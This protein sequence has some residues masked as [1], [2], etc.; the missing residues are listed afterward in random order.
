MI[1]HAPDGGWAMALVVSDED[2]R[3]L[4]STLTALLS[5]LASP[6]PEHWFERVTGEL[7][8]LLRAETSQVAL[9]LHG[10]ARTFSTD[11][12]ALAQSL[13]AATTFKSGE[14]HFHEGVMEG[15]LEL[16]RE[17]NLAVFTSAMLD[18]ASGGRRKESDFYNEVCV[19]ANALDTYGFLIAGPE[20]EALVGVNCG[21]SPVFDPL[22]SDTFALLQLL[23]PALQ[24]GFETLARVGSA[25]NVLASTLDHQGVGMLVFDTATG[26]ELHRNAAL[27]SMLAD[28]T[29]SGEI[30]RDARALAHAFRV[31]R[32]RKNKSSNEMDYCAFGARKTSGDV[33]LHA[34]FLPPGVFDAERGILITAEYST[35][36]LPG[37]AELRDALGLTAREAQVTLRLAAGQG[38]A[39]IARELGISAHTVRH[40]VERIF[41]KLGVHSRKALGLALLRMVSR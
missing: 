4:V 14:L 40:H 28:S 9:V 39:A 18:R 6:S 16:R 26:R 33:R 29:A 21:A 17:R 13:E 11:C 22:G 5:P 15:G 3:R 19:P 37:A 27:R 7:K 12:P 8:K 30:E 23:L 34:T 36:Q 25:L 1:E 31:Q 24:C 2:Q 10:R 20:G 35:P 38:D 32:Q 41:L